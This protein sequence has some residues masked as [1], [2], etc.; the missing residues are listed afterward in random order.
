[1]RTKKSVAFGLNKLQPGVEHVENII[2]HTKR[3]E[4]LNTYASQNVRNNY[5]DRWIPKNF[6]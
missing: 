4:G 1:M 2:G 3:N 6:L 5:A